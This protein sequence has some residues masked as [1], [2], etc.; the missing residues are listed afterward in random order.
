MPG[1]SGELEARL[2]RLEDLEEIRQLFVDYGRYLDRGD[3]DAYG[4]IFAEEGELLLGPLGRAK[5]RDA[6]RAL[7]APVVE[8]TGGNSFHLITAPVI[9]LD[10][11]RARSNVQW[12]ALTRGPDGRPAMTM[13]GHHEDELVRED[14]RWRIA[15]RKGFVELPSAYPS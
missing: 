10:G 9:E 7:M 1:S 11:D 2:A 14:G 6:I 15:R 13:F 4:A 8:G 5:G 3:L 12:T